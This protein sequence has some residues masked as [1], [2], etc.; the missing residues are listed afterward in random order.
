MK[1]TEKQEKMMDAHVETIQFSQVTPRTIFCVLVSKSGW[2]TYG[3]SACK[4]IKKFDEKK[5]QRY[6]LL[7]AIHRLEYEIDN[8]SEV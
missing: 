7:H 6:A 2:E 1:L 4:D 5:G 3:I 8:H